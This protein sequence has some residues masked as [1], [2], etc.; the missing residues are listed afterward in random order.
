MEQSDWQSFIDFCAELDKDKMAELLDLLLTVAEKEDISARFSIIKELLAG[1]LPHRQIAQK[2]NLSIAKI[3][4]G[5]NALK[6]AKLSYPE[7]LKNISN[8]S[9]GVIKSR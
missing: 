8:V 7:L 2:L 1:E 9:S 5:S 6:V 4:R 3:S